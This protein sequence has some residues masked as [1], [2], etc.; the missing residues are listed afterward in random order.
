M[1]TLKSATRLFGGTLKRITHYS[2]AC[3][4]EMTF[5][6]YLPPQVSRYYVTQ[7]PEMR[8]SGLCRTAGHCEARPSPLL[9]LGA[10]V[11]RRELCT[12]KRVCTSSSKARACPSAPRHESTR[13]LHRGSRRLL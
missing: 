2:E 8:H 10:H 5:A 9:A 11:Q 6:V 13:C 1:A 4:C 12:E 3:K 7:T